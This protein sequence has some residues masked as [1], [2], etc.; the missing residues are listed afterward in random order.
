MG[1]NIDYLLMK[2]SFYSICTKNCSSLAKKYAS[3]QTNSE[4]GNRAVSEACIFILKKFF[5]K[6]IENI[7]N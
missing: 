7:Y 5:K 4:G 3:H 2:K 1:E 6:R